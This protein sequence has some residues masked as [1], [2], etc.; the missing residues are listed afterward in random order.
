LL[1]F[2]PDF[3]AGTCRAFEVGFFAVSFDC[4]G[5]FFP[6]PDLGDFLRVFLDIRLPFVA[7]GGSIMEL[8]RVLPR[9]AGFES[10]AGQG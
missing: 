3:L 9:K 1:V 7:F 6:D 4:A 10:A 5:A 2:L 8:L